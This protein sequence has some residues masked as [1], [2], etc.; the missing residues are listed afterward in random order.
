MSS[1]SN[2]DIIA[3][4]FC[5]AP[6]FVT[7]DADT[8]ECYNTIIDN[9]RC[10]VNEG[11]V[12]C[13]TT[14]AYAY[15]LAHM[16]TIRSNPSI[17][18]ASSISEGDLSIAYSISPESGFLELTPWGRAYIDLIKRTIFAPTISNLPANFNPLALYGSCGC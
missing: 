15:L 6:Q 1:P 7:E 12:K 2:S 17:G 9:L 16:L 18:V 4:L 13:C 8:L 3:L 11:I 10:Q 5:I 14:L